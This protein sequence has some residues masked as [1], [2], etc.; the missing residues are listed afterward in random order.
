MTNSY[1]R[2]MEKRKKQAVCHL[3]TYFYSNL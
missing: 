2:R 1:R 3:S